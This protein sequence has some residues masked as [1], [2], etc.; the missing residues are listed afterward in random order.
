MN[1]KERAHKYEYKLNDTDD[2]IIDYILANKETV[3]DTSIQ[4]LAKSLYT[5]P[6]TITRLSKK[7]GYDGFSQ[8]KNNLKEEQEDDEEN[9][10]QFNIRKTLEILD[11]DMLRKIAKKIKQSRHVY[12]FGVGDTAPFCEIMATHFKIGGMNAEFFL[13]RHDAVYAINHAKKQDV[14]FLIS[15]SGETEQIIEMAELAKEKEITIISFTHFSS[16]T[17]EKMSDY[18]FFFYS[19]KRMLENYNISDKTPMM[20]A[21]QQ[22]SNVFWETT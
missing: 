11:D 22:L 17:L 14:L 15:M 8:L 20:L 10:A 7:L 21:L 16:N 9:A 12:L 1:L 2:Q 5:V 6:N 13:H 3:I 4:A 19:P 18:R